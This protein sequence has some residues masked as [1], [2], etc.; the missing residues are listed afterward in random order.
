MN[1]AVQGPPDGVDVFGKQAHILPIAVVDPKEE[2]IGQLEVRREKIFGGMRSGA[3]RVLEIFLPAMLSMDSPPETIAQLLQIGESSPPDEHTTN[4]RKWKDSDLTVDT[5]L[6]M[7]FPM[8]TLERQV[9]FETLMKQ[10]S[11]ARGS[12]IYD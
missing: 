2:E 3:R 6:D 4:S 9:P 8:S 7:I 1:E 11:E 12:R 10:V 5:V